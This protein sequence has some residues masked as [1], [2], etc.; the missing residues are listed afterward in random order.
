MKHK[1]MVY[2]DS[3]DIT[4]SLE[5][6]CNT[7]SEVV[8]KLQEY[9]AQYGDALIR[10]STSGYDSPEIT[11]NYEREETDEEYNRRIKYEERVEKD[12]LKKL[13]KRQK[14]IAKKA[15]DERQL[16]E[17]LKEKYGNN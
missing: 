8:A 11:L 6:D 5:Y 14:R 7:I 1:K 2:S 4:D 13:Q 9:Q 17:K 3:V 10:F 16:Y 15:Q 12:R